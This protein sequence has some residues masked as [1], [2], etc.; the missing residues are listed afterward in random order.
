MPK[1]RDR[2]GRFIRGNQA[3][4]IYRRDVVERAAQIDLKADDP[5]RDEKGR[6]V[7]G[8]EF[9]PFSLVLERKKQRCLH[10]VDVVPKTDLDVEKE[11][12]VEVE[13][14]LELDRR[15]ECREE[16]RKRIRNK[17]WCWRARKRELAELE[18]FGGADQDKHRIRSDPDKGGV[19]SLPD[20]RAWHTHRQ[21]C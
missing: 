17:V 2:Q 6:F 15:R 8:H 18:I 11:M 3:R 21:A 19:P 12:V 14:F 1:D 4:R 5:N 9:S 10:T 13:Y 16:Q 7:K 20:L